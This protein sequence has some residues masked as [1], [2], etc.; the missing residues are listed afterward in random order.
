MTFFL[1]DASTK[2]MSHFDSA[3]CDIVFVLL[4]RRFMYVNRYS[5]DLISLLFET[6]AKICQPYVIDNLNKW[7][8]TEN[9]MLYYWHQSLPIAPR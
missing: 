4:S 5:L 3:Q 2:T 8:C 6:C 9:V 7:F 1:V